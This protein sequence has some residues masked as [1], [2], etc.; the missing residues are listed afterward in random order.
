MY[1]LGEA[2]NIDLRTFYSYLYSSVVGFHSGEVIFYGHLLRTDLHI[3]LPFT[4]RTRLQYWHNYWGHFYSFSLSDH[5]MKTVLE[6]LNIMISKR[7]KQV[8]LTFLSTTSSPL[9][10]FR[11]VCLF[12]VVRCLYKDF[13]LISNDY[14]PLPYIIPFRIRFLCSAMQNYFCR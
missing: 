12:I 11:R 3:V 6:C 9:K 5:D 14:V 10:S 1:C 7:R 2:L 8:H 13:L 4:I